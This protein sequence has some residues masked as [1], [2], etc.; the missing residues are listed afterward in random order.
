[1]SRLSRWAHEQKNKSS[2]NDFFAYKSDY[3]K[4]F[5]LYQHITSAETKNEP[6]EYLEFGVAGGSS[7]KW[8]VEHNTNPQSRFHGFDTFEGLPEA[9]GPFKAGDMSTG[10]KQPDIK[11]ARVKFY[12]GL[13]QQT[14]PGF[15]QQY[16]STN[17]KLIHMDA[18]LYTSTL[19]T[20]T[21]L[22]PLLKK[23]DIILF[24]EYLVPSHEFLAFD[25][26]IKSYYI[27]TEFIG[28]ANNYLFTAFKI[29]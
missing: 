11:D 25:N 6:I 9:W 5:S 4:R 29:V 17:R 28:A 26:F 10:S 19:F 14:L 21:S 24:D 18:D 27:N 3:N 1:M 8:W 15:I 22:A 16:N 7:F 2:F 12:K 13:F 23:G 20:L